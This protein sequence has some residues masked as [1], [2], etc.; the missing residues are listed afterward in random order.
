MKSYLIVSP[1]ETIATLSCNDLRQD[2][3]HPNEHVLVDPN[4][5]LIDA[6][7]ILGYKVAIIPE[8]NNPIMR[9]IP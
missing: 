9:P 6:R 4:G 5:Q 7:I 2:L 1:N 8:A 3:D